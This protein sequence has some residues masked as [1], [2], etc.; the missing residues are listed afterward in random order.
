MSEDNCSAGSSVFNMREGFN[1][2]EEYLGVS[3]QTGM[4]TILKVPGEAV[5]EVGNGLVAS[6][7]GPAVLPNPAPN[8]TTYNGLQVSE[9][10][11]SLKS[12]SN[13]VGKR[14]IGTN[15]ATVVPQPGDIYYEILEDYVTDVV[16]SYEIYQ[17]FIHERHANDWERD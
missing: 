13:G 16:G 10:G 14:Y 6:T 7:D 5:S 2:D 9:D 17:E 3:Q 11:V 4:L 1:P 12:D 8:N 15:H